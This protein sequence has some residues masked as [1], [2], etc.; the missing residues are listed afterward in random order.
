MLKKNNMKTLQE[1][2]QNYTTPD[3]NGDKGTA[4]T[5]I[6]VYESVLAP[7]RKNGDVFEIGISLGYS[8]KM[9]GEYF[10][11][12]KIVGADIIL[13]EE[14]KQLLDNPRYQLIYEDA[15]KPEILSH[16]EGMKF[17]VII[18]DGSHMFEDQVSSFNILKSLV[19][20]G[21]VYII[22]DVLNIENTSDKFKSLHSNCEIID[23]RHIKNRYDDVLVIYRF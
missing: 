17:D 22:E 5:Y 10:I 7:Y 18:D 6:D 11:N 16:L 3:G 1:I 4:H 8:I 13:Y 23:N 9:W 2:Y 20:P 15:T 21:G 12:G 14:A 19:K